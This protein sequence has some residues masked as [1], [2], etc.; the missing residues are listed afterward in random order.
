LILRL[1]LADLRHEWLLSLCMILAIASILTPLMIL[2]GL[3]FGTIETFRHR[4]LENPKNREIRP[5]TSRAYDQSWF[6]DVAGWPGVAF[7]IP[8][9]RQMSASLDAYPGPPS[10]VPVSLDIIPTGPGDAWL[11]A[12]NL[13]VPADYQAVLSAPAAKVLEGK[14]GMRLRV[15]VKKLLGTKVEQVETELEVIE[16]FTEGGPESR[17]V[18]TSLAFL[19]KVEAYRDGQAVPELGWPGSRPLARPVFTAALLRSAE[20]LDPV[21]EFKTINNTGFVAINQVDRERASALLGR[22]VVPEGVYYVLETRGE[23]ARTDNLMA[24]AGLFRGREMEL[25]PLAE[26]LEVT[27]SGPAGE[28]KLAL[29]PAAA[30]DVA[31]KNPETPGSL[32][33]EAPPSAWLKLGVAPGGRAAGE[34]RLTFEG[35]AGSLSFPVM[36]EESS[37]IT[38][39]AVAS[40]PLTLLGILAQA[41]R[42]PLTFQPE[43]NS[44]LLGRRAY[45]GFRL[46]AET[47]EDVAP[48]QKRFEEEG[49]TV[50]AETARIEEMKRLDK[51]LTLIFWLITVGA[52]VGAAASLLSNVYASLERKRR[53]L[54]VLRLLGIS[55]FAFLR[56]PVYSS[57]LL[58]LGGFL[59][60]WLLFSGLSA[61]INHLFDEHLKAGESLCRLTPEH[62]LSALGL[63]LAISALAGIAAAVRAAG[64]EPSE[65]LRDE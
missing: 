44:F 50:A 7:V 37:D 23:P 42:R 26:S 25:Y 59:S 43:N 28:T 39:T 12:S 49:L 4:L 62:L 3:K 46:Y 32:S 38:G 47:L 45:A 11:E 61:L 6:T 33:A 21:M 1:A 55:G 31:G 22:S 15:A 18:F 65:A 64:I 48:L 52:I 35:R 60:S 30:L 34:A 16:L 58:T 27:L 51:Y 41:D 20:K 56:F 40:A 14:P 8:Y 54:G 63:S 36:V 24:L 10:A 29:A 13:P 17:A 9:T 57:I 53:E 19:E 5:L 2:F